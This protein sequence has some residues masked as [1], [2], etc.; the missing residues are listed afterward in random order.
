MPYN[1]FGRVVKV[2]GYFQFGPAAW[3]NFID[4]RPQSGAVID[5]SLMSL[6]RQNSPARRIDSQEPL[7]Q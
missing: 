4:Q 7:N 2:L 5:R 6:L 1:C 3:N